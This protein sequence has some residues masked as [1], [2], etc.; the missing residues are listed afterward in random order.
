ML[1]IALAL[2]TTRIWLPDML[3][4]NSRY[5]SP[6]GSYCV[7]V[8]DFVNLP[9]HATA[10]AKV[11]IED[12]NPSERRATLYAKKKRVARTRIVW[13]YRQLLTA[14]SGQFA[15]VRHLT[16]PVLAETPVLDIFTNGAMRTLTAGDVFAASDFDALNGYGF[17]L[18]AL[19]DGG[20]LIVD[21]DVRVD[22]ATATRVDPLR[23]RHPTP[24]VWV[25]TDEDVRERAIDRPVPAYPPV[26]VKA[27]IAGSVLIEIAVSPKGQVTVLVLHFLD[28]KAVED[29]I[30]IDLATGKRIGPPVNALAVPRL[31]V[32]SAG[33]LPVKH[34][35]SWSPARCLGTTDPEPPPATRISSAE[36]LARAIS[37]PLE[38]NPQ[39]RSLRMGTVFFDVTVAEN[40]SVLCTSAI[41]IPPG[42]HRFALDDML[43]NWRF[44]PSADKYRG[45]LQFHFDVLNDEEC[46]RVGCDSEW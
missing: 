22:L 25:V 24:R 44:A 17:E 34:R 23:D 11:A 21:R 15:V 16:R 32:S 8:R 39:I 18:D 41:A 36:L 45:E 14:D 40:G 5:C 4:R 13:P 27:R 30:E 33:Y 2:F 42:S 46:R 12:N 3:V 43:R 6:N 29:E 7:V 38:L 10:R 1:T 19:V 31:W 35:V 26:A 28:E 20:E 37:R 9:D